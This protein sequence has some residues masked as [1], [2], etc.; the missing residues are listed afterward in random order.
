MELS[1]KDAKQLLR[2]GL[3]VFCTFG[4]SLTPY[5]VRAIGAKNL[6]FVNGALCPKTGFENL[7]FYDSID[8]VPVF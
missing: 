6:G 4:D 8:A 7:R 5:Q 1:E 3:K 2:L